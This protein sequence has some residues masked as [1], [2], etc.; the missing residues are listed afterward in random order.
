MLALKC[1]TTALYPCLPRALV[2]VIALHAR[3]S[4][5]M[6]GSEN[7]GEARIDEEVDLPVEMEPVRPMRSMSGRECA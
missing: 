2:G 3:Q 4:A 7:G 6:T 5:S 1:L